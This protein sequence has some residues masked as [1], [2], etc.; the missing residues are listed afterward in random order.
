MVFVIEG[1]NVND[2]YHK[3]KKLIAGYALKEDSRAGEVRV[4]PAPVLSVYHRPWERVLLD[5]ERNA[6]VFFHLVE[7]LWMLAGQNNASVLNE[8]IHDFGERFAEPDG[9]IHDAYGARW[10][11]GLGFDQ[12]NHIVDMLRNDSTTRQAVL[13]MW[14]G[15]NWGERDLTG[16]WRTRP[17]NTHIY[18]RVRTVEGESESAGGASLIHDVLDMTV[19]CRSNDMVW[20][21]YGANAVHFSM[22][23]EY[24]AGRV[25]ISMGKMYQFS[26]NFHV[27]EDIVKTLDFNA[28]LDDLV[29]EPYKNS[30]VSALSMGDRWASWDFDLTLFMDWLEQADE[31]PPGGFVN[32]WFERVAVNMVLA[33][34]AWKRRKDVTESLR[35]LNLV[36]A[37]DFQRAGI[38]WIKR[39]IA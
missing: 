17:C 1:R 10:R 16:N 27:Y 18:F 37:S 34:R 25:G 4:M 14:D 8:F 9:K 20:G 2:L 3:G 26:N 24:V 32:S 38:D 13:Q 19:S 28:S 12:L 29:R 11:R 6:N 21:A 33:F 7:G 30:D 22:L 35:L 5:H 31:S 36:P 23:M 39:R 15:T